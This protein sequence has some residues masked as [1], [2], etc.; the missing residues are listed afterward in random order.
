MSI[1]RIAGLMMLVV[2]IALLVI[3]H[4]ATD[5]PVEQLS[6]TLTGR[7]SQDTLWYLIGGGAALVGGAALALFGARR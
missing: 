2:G 3:G 4:D 5:S 7:Y 1:G 6:K